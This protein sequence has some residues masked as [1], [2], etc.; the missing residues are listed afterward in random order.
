[1][2]NVSGLNSLSDIEPGSK[3]N[4]DNEFFINQS[5]KRSN[6]SSKKTLSDEND[7][8]NN[9]HATNSTP[10]GD[11][12][13]YDKG[14]VDN[15]EYDNDYVDNH[16]YDNDHITQV[17]GDMPSE[18]NSGTSKSSKS[19]LKDLQ[20][21]PINKQNS[22]QQNIDQVFQKIVANDPKRKTVRDQKFISML[23][24]DQLPINIWE[25]TG[26]IEFLAEFDPNY[27]LPCERH[28]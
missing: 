23:I 4:S 12:N 6:L 13:E 7:E 28:C 9:N 26:F 10:S 5:K 24:K 19:N 22:K 16:E 17:T 15:I 3:E 14:Y 1:Q 8:Y 11:S 27:R 18:N 2:E 25:G 20:L 21:I